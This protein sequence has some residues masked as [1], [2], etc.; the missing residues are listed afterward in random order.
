MAAEFK[1]SPAS[2]TS[3]EK[4]LAALRYIR[5]AVDLIEAYVEETGELPSW[6]TTKVYGAAKD[7]GMCVSATRQLRQRRK[8]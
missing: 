6:V 4:T 7:L 2:L 1:P 3:V 5:K 8:K